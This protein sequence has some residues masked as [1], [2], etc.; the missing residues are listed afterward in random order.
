MINSHI[1][2][3]G[4]TYALAGLV[5][6]AQFHAARA[7]DLGSAINKVMQANQAAAKAQKK[8]DKTSDQTT[9]LLGQ[10][11]AVQEQIESAKAYNAQVQKLLDSQQGEMDLLR[12]Q[13]DDATSIGREITPLMIRMIDSLD[14]FIKLDVPFLM[15]ERTKRIATLRKMMDR[16]DVA[17]SEKFR[18]ILEAY[19]IETE[20]GRTIEAYEAELELNGKKRMVDFLRFGRIALMYLTLDESEAGVWNQESRSW[21]VLPS[22]YRSSIKKG[23]RIAKK[24]TAPDLIRIP[25][26]SPE[27]EQ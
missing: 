12:K 16:A 15:D 6:F 19:Q 24:Q 26:A 25:I 13:I 8:I 21:D 4:V 10:Y 11:R 14:A 17:D 22:E 7:G 20:F 1:M 27:D 9:E 23:I 5:L 18:R 2:A 3:R